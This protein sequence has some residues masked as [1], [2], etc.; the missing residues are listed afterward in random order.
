MGRRHRARQ[1]PPCPRPLKLLAAETGHA[2]LRA[3]TVG[4]LLERWFEA[5]SPDWATT[6]ASQ[7]RSTM[8]CHLIPDLGHVSVDKLTTAD[9]DDF[10]AHLL[11][12]G[13][14][15][16]KPLRP[17]TVNRVHVVLHRAL[18]QA[19]VGSG[20]GATRP[21]PPARPASSPPRS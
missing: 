10:C 2:H 12:S 13:G 16:T 6:T 11:R 5:A 1:P 19:C 14:I 17:G 3:G 9:I 21:A 20:S 15:H 4:D 18:A 7:T 8:D